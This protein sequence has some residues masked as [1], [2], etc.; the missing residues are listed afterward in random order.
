MQAVQM[1]LNF[2]HE[3]NEKERQY[4]TLVNQES[5]Q[6]RERKRHH[7]LIVRYHEVDREQHELQALQT[8]LVTP[9]IPQ[10]SKLFKYIKLIAIFY[11]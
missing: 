9:R 2:E 8:Q 10:K 7:E 3:E 11:S 5:N 4:E 1:K 6:E